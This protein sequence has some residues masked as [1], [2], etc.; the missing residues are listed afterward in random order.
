VWEVNE[1][2]PYHPSIF[3]LPF[4]D[5]EKAAYHD[6]FDNGGG[7]FVAALS[8]DSLDI[9]SLNEFLSWSGFSLSYTEVG[10][11]SQPVLITDKTAHPTTEGVSDFDYLGAPLNIP[12]G[13]ISLGRHGS[14]TV[15]A[16]FQG[17]GGG[18]IVISGSN[19]HIDNYGMS[20]MYQ[21]AYD[22]ILALNIAVWLTQL[23]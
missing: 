10:A 11:G 22:D 18:R 7:I 14:D 13:A 4:S 15:L 9:K 20:H 21:S 16:C 23:I 1:T 3:S 8:N 17:A 2:D 12:V 19:F 6:Y 5:S